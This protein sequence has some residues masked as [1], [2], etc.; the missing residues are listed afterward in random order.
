M[1]ILIQTMPTGCGVHT[2]QATACHGMSIGHKGLLMAVKSIASLGCDLFTDPELLEL[3]KADLKKR[4]GD[5]IFQTPL[6]PEMKRPMGLDH[7]G[8]PDDHPHKATLV[9]QLK[10]HDPGHDQSIAHLEA[11]VRDVHGI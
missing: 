7:L 9:A 10:H 1:G 8:L 6:D 5:F 11:H 3:A 2:W 4:K